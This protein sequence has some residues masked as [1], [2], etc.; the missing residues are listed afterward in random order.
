M[1]AQYRQAAA[2]PATGALAALALVLG[3]D[4]RHDPVARHRP[5]GT[6]AAYRNLR[7]SYF[8][9]GP[10]GSVGDRFSDR[11]CLFSFLLRTYAC[12]FFSPSDLRAPAAPAPPLRPT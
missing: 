2:F 12:H 8:N 5:D 1:A 9:G 11:R 4:H 6:A 3:D 10:D 7:L